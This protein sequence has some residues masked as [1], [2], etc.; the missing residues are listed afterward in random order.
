MKAVIT[1][2]F[3][4]LL[5]TVSCLFN[6]RFGGRISLKITL[7]SSLML[8]VISLSLYWHINGLRQVI[9]WQTAIAKAPFL[10]S[11]KTALNAKQEQMIALALRTRLQTEQNNA[12]AWDLLGKL[13]ENAGEYREALAAYRLAWMIEP[14]NITYS[15]N[16]SDQLLKTGD[17]RNIGLARDILVKL[18]ER[19][20]NDIKIMS[21]LAYIALSM[22]DSQQAKTWFQIILKQTKKHDKR[23]EFIKRMI[24]SLNQNN[25]PNI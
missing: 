19:H 24:S 14:M 12:Q 15:L 18:N 4:C 21:Q 17:K 10:I 9:N 8:T 23:Y 20:P 3:I 16:Y 1:V 5:L 6:N 2:I 7:F 25:N 13:K 22:D 11:S